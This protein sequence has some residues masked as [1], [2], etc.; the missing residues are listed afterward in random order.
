MHVRLI[1]ETVKYITQQLHYVDWRSQTWQLK[2]VA[3]YTAIFLHHFIVMHFISQDLKVRQEEAEA[4]AR[5]IAKQKE[6]KQKE[7]ER[8]RE[9]EQQQEQP[10]FVELSDEEAKKV[11][12][13]IDEEKQD[14][15]SASPPKDES[16]AE[17]CCHRVLILSNSTFVAIVV[18]R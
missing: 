3:G 14:N 2:V 13:K 8:E 17:A 1:K 10:K 16:T 11:Q 5:R 15:T 7:L 9:L 12:Q 6:K 4:R 18:F